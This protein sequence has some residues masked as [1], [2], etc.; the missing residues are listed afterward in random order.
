MSGGLYLIRRMASADALPRLNVLMRYRYLPGTDGEVQLSRRQKLSH[1]SSFIISRANRSDISGVTIWSQRAHSVCADADDGRQVTVICRSD[2]SFALL[3]PSVH[4]CSFALSLYEYAV[5]MTSCIVV[6][7]FSIRTM[8][9]LCQVAHVL[10][11]DSIIADG[12]DG[13][14]AGDHVAH[15]AV[16]HQHLVSLRGLVAG[17]VAVG[18]AFTVIDGL[19]AGGQPAA[20]QLN[21]WA[22]TAPCRTSIFFSPAAAP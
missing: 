3:F 21:G 1:W 12:V 16:H 8:H 13:L 14:A 4:R 7:P 5:L 20:V 17:V 15:F 6:S 2:A 9:S 18:A 10:L 19:V 22:C 11:P